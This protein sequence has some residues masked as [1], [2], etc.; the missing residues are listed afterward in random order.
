[1]SKKNNFNIISILQEHGAIL[2]G[3]FQ[4]PNGLHS[5]NYIQT[6]LV[7]QYPHLLTKIS[8]EMSDLFKKSTATVILAPTPKISVLAQE[9]A[10]LRKARA[11]FAE[12]YKGDSMK[13][14]KALAPKKGDKVLIVD[15][16]TTTGKLISAAIAL[17]KSSGAEIIGV[18]SVADRSV[19]DLGLQVP[20][21]ALMS[22]PLETYTEEK[23]PLCKK[24]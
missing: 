2:K 1:M 19:G 13:I 5:E 4:L 6:F 12:K 17:C 9:I 16:V 14:K 11:V 22:F 8:Q 15:D 23:C 24:R 18:A 21:R 10:R 7:T 20:I 3:H